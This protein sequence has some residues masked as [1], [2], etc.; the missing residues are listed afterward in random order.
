[1]TCR[2]F[3]TDTGVAVGVGDTL[4]AMRLYCEICREPDDTGLG[5]CS[6]CQDES[7]L[8]EEPAEDDE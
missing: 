7:Y 3:G 1:M 2:M 4:V 6:E 5:I 8:Q